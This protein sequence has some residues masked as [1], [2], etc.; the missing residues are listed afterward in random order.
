LGKFKTNS[1]Q[2]IGKLYRAFTRLVDARAN[3]EKDAGG[4]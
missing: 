3:D 2:N 1:L 4:G